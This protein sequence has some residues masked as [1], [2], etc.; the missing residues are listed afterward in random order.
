MGVFQI[1]WHRASS[2]FKSTVDVFF[3]LS[4]RRTWSQTE[5][6]VIACE[7]EP[8]DLELALLYVPKITYE[9]SANGE[10]FH[11]TEMIRQKPIFVRNS[12][13]LERFK[14]GTKILVMYSPENP[15]ITHL[16]KI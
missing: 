7:S 14:R 12:K 15:H 3:D 2:F 9:F 16:V 10:E 11:C 6:I 8:L 5:A 1:G 4:Q 13:M